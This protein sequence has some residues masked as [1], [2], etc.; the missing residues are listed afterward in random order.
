MSSGP[1]HKRKV[2]LRPGKKGMDVLSQAKHISAN[3]GKAKE[4]LCALNISQGATTL[5]VVGYLPVVQ[6]SKIMADKFRIAY[7]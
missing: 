2:L 7:P 5:S 4:F 3:W 1:V 6:Q